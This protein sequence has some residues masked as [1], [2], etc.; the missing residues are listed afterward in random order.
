V[1]RVSALQTAVASLDLPRVMPMTC[2]RGK[3]AGH[4]V[5]PA[6]LCKQG[7]GGSSPLVSTLKP[8]GQ[9]SFVLARSVQNAYGSIEPQIDTLFADVD[10]RWTGGS[11]SDFF[12]P[13]GADG[14]A[15]ERARAALHPGPP[16]RNSPLKSGNTG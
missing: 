6:L 4:S 12:F 13:K 7:V 3:T 10:P 11:P 14:V 16:A 5:V 15:A 1:Y 8:A 9:T 2:G